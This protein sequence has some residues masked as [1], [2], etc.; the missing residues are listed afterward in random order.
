MAKK[1][2]TNPSSITSYPLYF[3]CG[4]LRNKLHHFSLST[5]N[6]ASPNMEEFIFDVPNTRLIKIIG[7]STSLK[8]HLYAVNFIS[9]WKAYPLK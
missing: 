2:V 3:F 6:N 4:Y 5:P 1:I 9:I 7:T 8:P